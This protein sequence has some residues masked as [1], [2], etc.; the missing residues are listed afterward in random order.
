MRAVTRYLLFNQCTLTMNVMNRNMKNERLAIKLCLALAAF[1]LLALS[2]CGNDNASQGLSGNHKKSVPAIEKV[3]YIEVYTLGHVSDSFRDAMVDSLR[4]V[5]PRC[6]FV[7]NVPLPKSAYYVPMH[8]YLAKNLTVYLSHWRTKGNIVLGLTQVDISLNNFRGVPNR[9]IM[10][11][12]YPMGGNVC[13]FSNYRK[14]SRSGL[15]VLMKHELGHVFGLN[16][17][18]TPRC[19]MQDAKGKDLKGTEFCPKCAKYLRGKHWHI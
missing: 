5:Y 17:C 1:F 8:R 6:R 14:K 13:V 12:T 2:S 9:G 4:T 7:K 15:F 19:L 10:G 18:V 16:H 11:L 3:P